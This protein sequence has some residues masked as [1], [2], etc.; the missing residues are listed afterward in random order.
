[1]IHDE[2]NDKRLWSIKKRVNKN[3]KMEK[4]FL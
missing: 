2:I 1:M 3:Q 4:H